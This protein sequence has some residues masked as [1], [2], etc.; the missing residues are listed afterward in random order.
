MRK[1]RGFTLI[2]LMV[3]MVI[4][5]ILA[6]IALPSYQSH[7]V[8]TRRATA[9]ACLLEI[10]QHLERE[11][12]KYMSYKDAKVPG[13]GAGSPAAFQCQTELAQFYKF[14]FSVMATNPG[15]KTFAIEAVPLGSQAQDPNCG[16]LKLDQ[17]GVK[18]ATG[19]SPH[20]CW[21]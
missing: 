12:T 19:G 13:S 14:Q 1:H 17:A 15:Y 11:A 21:K 7:M 18:T 20:L 10:A 9:A 3:V 4:V 5:A 16:T 2:E 6:A 8:R